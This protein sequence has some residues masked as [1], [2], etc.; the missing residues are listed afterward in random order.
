MPLPLNVTGSDPTN[1]S[2]PSNVLIPPAVIEGAVAKIVSAAADLA[3]YVAS[4]DASQRRHLRRISPRDRDGIQRAE[5]IARAFPKFR[6]GFLSID[7]F[8]A[9][10]ANTGGLAALRDPL[11]TLSARVNDTILLE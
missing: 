10:L 6:P 11:A 7:E 3:P 8:T 1:D 2:P 4:V 5:A 9:R